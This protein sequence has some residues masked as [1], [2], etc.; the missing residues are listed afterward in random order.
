MVAG[1]AAALSFHKQFLCS[2]KCE[3]PETLTMWGG[4]FGKLCIAVSLKI[5]AMPLC[6]LMFVIIL[7]TR[8]NSPP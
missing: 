3:K 1:A 7:E 6:L 2:L 5:L 4:R 8:V